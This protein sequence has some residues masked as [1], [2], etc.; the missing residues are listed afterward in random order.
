MSRTE[1][2]HQR[3]ITAEVDGNNGC[4]NL[5]ASYQVPSKRENESFRKARAGPSTLSFTENERITHQLSHIYCSRLLLGKKP[6]H[7]CF[8]EIYFGLKEI[9][10]KFQ[11][12]VRLPQLNLKKKTNLSE[13]VGN[14]KSYQNDNFWVE[15]DFKWLESRLCTR[16]HAHTYINIL[17][18]NWISEVI[19]RL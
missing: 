14:L 15:P 8:L 3:R 12:S 10:V 4:C 17:S 11:R 19:S 5:K 18:R 13:I 7:R 6:W 9:M 2:S 16:T 1:T